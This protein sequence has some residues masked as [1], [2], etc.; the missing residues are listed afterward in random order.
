MKATIER[1]PTVEV[2]NVIENAAA[3]T[4]IEGASRY[5][6]GMLPKW[7][8]YK[9]GSHIAIHHRSHSARVAIIT[10]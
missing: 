1:Q 9:G 4:T 7:F 10:A 5:L 6:S 2:R 3:M 8:I